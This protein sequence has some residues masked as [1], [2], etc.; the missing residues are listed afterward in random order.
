MAEA[1]YVKSRMRVTVRGTSAQ[2]STVCT[3]LRLSFTERWKRTADSGPVGWLVGIHASLIRLWGIAICLWLCT[4]QQSE[5]Q[6]PTILILIIITH[7]RGL[8]ASWIADV[9]KYCIPLVNSR[10]S[11]ILKS[12][13]RI[14]IHRL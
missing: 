10:G 9:M 13:Y 11:S 6:S 12:A 4:L 2:F 1:Y 3:I 7:V 14:N 8:I 5:K